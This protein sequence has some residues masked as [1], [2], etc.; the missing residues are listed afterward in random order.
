MQKYMEEVE[1]LIEKSEREKLDKIAHLEQ[2]QL[3]QARS[4]ELD[5]ALKLR[6]IEIKEKQK[7]E[8]KK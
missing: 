5:K 2:L 6:E 8:Y 3:T 7:A 1:D 4:E